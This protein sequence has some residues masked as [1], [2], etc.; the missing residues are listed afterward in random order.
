MLTEAQEL[1]ELQALIALVRRSLAVGS[2]LAPLSFQRNAVPADT[3][4]YVVGS[5]QPIEPKTYFLEAYYLIR[6]AVSGAMQVTRVRVSIQGDPAA[7]VL[8][9]NTAEFTAQNLAAG[10]T[11][12]VRSVGI[13]INF[14]ITNNAPNVNPIN[15]QV[16]V[17]VLKGP[18]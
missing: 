7:P 17:T 2:S 18:Q 16:L 12:N 5:I 1:Q 9:G 15:V 11:V 6:D 3:V 8:V 14:D 13:D 4:E 10:A